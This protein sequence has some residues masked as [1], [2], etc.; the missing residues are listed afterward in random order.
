ME[1]PTQRPVLMQLLKPLGIVDVGLA[2]GV[3]ERLA[4]L[5]TQAAKPVMKEDGDEER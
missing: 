4:T 3:T 1:A 2:T 5:L